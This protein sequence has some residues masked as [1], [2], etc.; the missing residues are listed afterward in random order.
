VDEDLA[1]KVAV[2]T[3][4]GS[5]IGEACS[6][7]LAR[8]GAAVVVSDIDAATADRVAQ[9]IGGSASSHVGDVSVPAD[10][11]ALV[12]TALDRHG[13]LDIA[14]NNAGIS[15]EQNPVGDLSV[16]GWRRTLGT[17]LDG[18]FYCMH[19]EIPAMLTVGGG[20]IVNMAS[21]LGSVGLA[22]AAAYVAAKHGVVGLSRAA[23]IEYADRG[24]R[25]NAVGP[26]FIDT[27]LLGRASAE[28]LAALT[29]L[30]PL[31]RMGTA[32]EVAEVVAFLVSDRASNVTGSYYTVDGGYTA[33]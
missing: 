33:R 31:G 29:A 24:V 12:A 10:C 20:S 15:G 27:P 18:V 5:G 14:V 11:E 8:R 23:A 4:G 16:T 22:N 28:V 32:Q 21:I 6:V 9:G 25:V 2:V 19:H 3:G 7:L 13:R 1:G 17:N 30:H 26:G